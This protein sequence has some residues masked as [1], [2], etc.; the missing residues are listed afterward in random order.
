MKNIKLILLLLFFFPIS[1]FADTE[2]VLVE[3]PKDIKKN[4]EF[5]KILQGLARDIENGDSLNIR[6]SSDTKNLLQ[7]YSKMNKAIRNIFVEREYDY[8]DLFIK[9]NLY[10]LGAF[11]K[12]TSKEELKILINSFEMVEKR[13]KNIEKVLID[14][15]NSILDNENFEIS[16][17]GSF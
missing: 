5:I 13:D 14:F 8:Y 16:L 9:N 17:S 10:R 15:Y 1:V 4:T 7:I 6:F 12:I 3:C 11:C 2:H